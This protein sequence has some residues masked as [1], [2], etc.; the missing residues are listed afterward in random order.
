L[1]VLCVL[2]VL[3]VRQQRHWHDSESLFLHELAINPESFLTHGNLGAYYHQRGD[4][5]AAERE[6]RRA[7]E[8]N[9]RMM[10]PR[11]NLAK[12]LA[13]EGRIA[14]ATAEIDAAQRVNPMLP[15]DEKL[16]LSDAYMTVIDEAQRINAT[17]PPERRADLSETYYRAALAEMKGHRPAQAA[18]FLQ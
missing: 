9:P 12:L 5:P 11:A 7:I 4:W 13:T 6:Y 8:I 1:A 18:P 14:D 10:I 2:A 15:P 17:L 16:D 3:N